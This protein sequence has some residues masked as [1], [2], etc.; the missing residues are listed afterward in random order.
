MLPK[1]RRAQR[2]ASSGERPDG[3]RIALGQL[4]VGPDFVVELAVHPP[5]P[6]SASSRRE[7]RGGHDFASRNLATSAVARSQFATSTRSC[8][9][10]AAVS[11]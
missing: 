6:D 4:E 1:R 11:E 9:V 7:R 8:R 10:P 5:R 3:D 2:R